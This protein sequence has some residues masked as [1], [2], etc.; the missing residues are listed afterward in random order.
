MGA[1]PAA[2]ADTS[3]EDSHECSAKVCRVEHHELL[4]EDKIDEIFCTGV[5]PKTGNGPRW[6]EYDKIR[7]SSGTVVIR[8]IVWSSR[9]SK[10]RPVW[11]MHNY[12]SASQSVRAS[13][14][15]S[16]ARQG[17]A[18]YLRSSALP[19]GQI[20]LKKNFQLLNLWPKERIA[21]Q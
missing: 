7:H 12:R 15:D 9:R 8:Q 5:N 10:H 14:Q 19:R 18:N 11:V 1:D 20:A 13:L 16:Y 3:L 17:S 6:T 2:Y 4:H 21:V